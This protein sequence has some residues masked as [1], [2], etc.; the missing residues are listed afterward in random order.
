MNFDSAIIST[1]RSRHYVI[2]VTF[3]VGLALVSVAPQ[4]VQKL[5]D[6]EHEVVPVAVTGT[7]SPFYRLV[8]TRLEIPA[9]ALETTFTEPLGLNPDK[10]VMVPETYTEVGWYKNGVTPGEVGA[11]VILGHVDSKAGPAVFF[12]LGQLE[13]GDEIMVTR[14]DNT[15]VTFVVDELQR[16][17]QSDFPSSRVYT[18]GDQAVLRLVTCTGTFDRKGERYSHNLVVYATLK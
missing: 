6:E 9:I 14:A 16:Y 10:T 17:L 15:V 3:V 11:A 18:S 13:V 2:V 12:S 1:V 5:N 8:P 7:S 4:V